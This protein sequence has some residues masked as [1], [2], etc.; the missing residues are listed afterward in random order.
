[1]K[2]LFADRVPASVLSVASVAVSNGHADQLEALAAAYTKLVE[3]ELGIVRADVK[4]AVPLTDDLRD[5]ITEKLSTAV[6]KRVVLREEV[7][8]AIIGGIVIN[9]AGRVL[10]SSLLRQLNDMRAALASAPVGGEA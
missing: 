8:A 10:D 9:V 4:T 2:E 7:D 3:T 5:K 1:M 6:G